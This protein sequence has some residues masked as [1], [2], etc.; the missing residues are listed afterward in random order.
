VTPPERPLVALELPPAPPVSRP[1][2]QVAGSPVASNPDRARRGASRR[3]FRS[4]PP[5]PPVTAPVHLLVALELPAAPPVNRAA[6]PPMRR[7]TVPALGLLALG[8]VLTVGPIA[9]G[10]FAK[11]AAGTQMVDQFAPLMTA[12]AL[13]RYGSDLETLRA[14]TAGID[15]VYRQHDILVGFFPELDA[16]RSQS[17]AILDR[18]SDLLHRVTTTEP[19][20]RQ[21]ADIGG[22]DRMPFLIVV[23]GIVSIYGGCVLLFG[24]AKRV[25]AVVVFVVLMA[26]AIAAYP[27]VSGLDSGAPAG[28]RM[29]QSLAPVMSSAEVRQLQRD[30]IV[31]VGADGE[32]ETSF[33]SVPKSGPAATDVTALV[34]R[35]PTVSSD[36]ATLVG[37]ID[38]NLGNFKALHDLDALTSAIGVSGFVAFPWFLVGS[39]ALSAGIALAA[40]PRRGKEKT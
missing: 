24:D 19:D 1:S 15:A 36:L 25:G 11:A 6:A 8:M 28:H 20:Y 16:Y 17:T 31:I 37:A 21:V 3:A 38:D 29:L 7:P 33:R 40:W 9:G 30:F 12:D 18:A 23:A 27:F 5:A 35:W 2:S 26:T 32:L 39:G 13:A 22:F 14:G 4:S 10:L 34:D